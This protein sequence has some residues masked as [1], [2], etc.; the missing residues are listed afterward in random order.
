MG[1]VGH[2]LMS[3]VALLAILA[4]LASGAAS[5]GVQIYFRRRDV[6]DHRRAVVGL[7]ADIVREL[8]KASD[9][10]A[11]HEKIA[12]LTGYSKLKIMEEQ[13][14]LFPV[15]A[16]ASAEA[17]LVV[18]Q[19]RIQ[20]RFLLKLLDSA[21]EEEFGWAPFHMS[22]GLSEGLLKKLAD[23]FKTPDPLYRSDPGVGGRRP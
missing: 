4:I 13:L 15:Y 16:L 6:R 10:L 21:H 19:L 3:P 11:R 9:V 20:L 2:V 22:V 5:A 14:S 8:K 18:F 12:A 23:L 1:G 7:V 17:T